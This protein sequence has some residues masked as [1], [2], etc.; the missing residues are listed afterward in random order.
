M[1]DIRIESERSTKAWE[2]LASSSALRRTL[3]HK[4][5]LVARMNNPKPKQSTN[6]KRKIDETQQHQNDNKQLQEEQDNPDNTTLSDGL[7]R[8]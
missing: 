6:K 3:R 4:R 1:K 7:P 5:I 2:L 8:R